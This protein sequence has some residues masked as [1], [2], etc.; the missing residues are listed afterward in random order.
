MASGSDMTPIYSRSQ[1]SVE[2]NDLSSESFHLDQNTKSLSVSA[3]FEE[4]HHTM[5]MFSLLANSSGNGTSP[6]DFA[7]AVR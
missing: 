2:F 5:N 6:N 1:R 4:V 3:G 7:D